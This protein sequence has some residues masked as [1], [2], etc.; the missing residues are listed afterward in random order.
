MEGANELLL[1]PHDMEQE[2]MRMPAVKSAHVSARLPD[3]LTVTIQE[4]APEAAW[5]VGPDI[6]RVANDGMVIDQG[7]P[8]GLKVVIGQVAGDP[9]KPG[10]TVDPNV[11]K[12]AEQL[13]SELAGRNGFASQRIQYSPADGLAVV[14]DNGLIA[15]FGSPS[16]LGLKV[17]ELQRIVQLAQD[18]KSP[19]TFVDLRYKTP[20][21]RTS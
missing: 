9:V 6:F 15:M 20:Y 5:V 19:L 14:G 12:G 2:I 8:D 21:Y 17:A 16:D 4:R 1:S 3:R 11:I 13:N 10:D 7:S 18:K